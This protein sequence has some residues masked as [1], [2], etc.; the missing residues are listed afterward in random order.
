MK[1]GGNALT[2]TSIQYRTT[3]ER[4]RQCSN[5]YN[6]LYSIEQQMKGGGN[7]LTITSIQYRT[8][9]ERRRQCSNN[10]IYTV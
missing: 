2:I 3:D 1:G 7:V 4:R 8:T 5:N 6:V 10:Y 9:D